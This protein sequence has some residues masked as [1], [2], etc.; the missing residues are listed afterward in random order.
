MKELQ[1]AHLVSR[2]IDEQDRLLAVHTDAAILLADPTKFG[3]R[4][5]M[6]AIYSK[7][8]DCVALL[9]LAVQGNE[10][11]ARR[12]IDRMRELVAAQ[13]GQSAE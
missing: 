12:R 5:F 10:E 13:A 11:Y 2:A 1:A 6:G 7:P 3:D 4:L 8:S 9:Q